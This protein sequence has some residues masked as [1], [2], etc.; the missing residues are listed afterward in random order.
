[1]D[2][3]SGY[4]IVEKKWQINRYKIEY[5]I[6]QGF[7]GRPL[8]KYEVSRYFLVPILVEKIDQT[9]EDDPIKSCIIN[10]PDAKLDFDK[11][12]ASIKDVR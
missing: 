2:S 7:S 3:M 6:D 9:V 4:Q 8:M 5:M 1:M 12:N 10:F 11:C